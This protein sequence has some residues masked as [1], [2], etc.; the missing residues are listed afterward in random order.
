MNT[1]KITMDGSARALARLPLLPHSTTPSSSRWSR[2]SPPADTFRG[3]FPEI[4]LSVSLENVRGRPGPNGEFPMAVG[5]WFLMLKA[6]DEV[7][8]VL[9][10]FVGRDLRLEIESTKRTVPAPCG[11]KFWIEI[12]NAMRFLIDRST[13]SRGNP[14]VGD[15]LRLFSENHR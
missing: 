3:Y 9:A 13:P 12:I 6:D 10:H 7:H 8:R 1:N 2:R 15:D 14:N 4:P 11:I 5:R